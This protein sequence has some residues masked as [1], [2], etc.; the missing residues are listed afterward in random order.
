MSETWTVIRMEDKNGYSQAVGQVKHNTFYLISQILSLPSLS[1]W[2]SIMSPGDAQFML[3]NLWQRKPE[4]VVKFRIF[5]VGELSCRHGAFVRRRHQGLEQEELVALGRNQIAVE[6]KREETQPWFWRW[7][8]G[9]WTKK[10]DYYRFGLQKRS[11]NCLFLNPP[12]VRE[13]FSGW[14]F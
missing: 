4:D 11:G 13:T 12:R 1:M 8:K 9:L 3:W 5:E 7:R 14:W 10:G 6:W 2:T